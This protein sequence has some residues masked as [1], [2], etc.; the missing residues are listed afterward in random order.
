MVGWNNIQ[1][2][3]TLRRPR[4]RSLLSAPDGQPSYPR[5]DPRRSPATESGGALD[6]EG[7]RRQKTG[8]SQRPRRPQGLHHFS[9][10]S[11]L[12]YYF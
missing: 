7:R 9:P 2:R 6:E 10:H 11:M 4:T 12:S 1:S 5:A 3:F 8:P